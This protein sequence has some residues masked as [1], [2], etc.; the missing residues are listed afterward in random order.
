MAQGF[1]FADALQ[2]PPPE[3]REQPTG[4]FSFADAVKPAGFSFAEASQP[5]STSIWTDAADF[6]KRMMGS[7]ISGIFGAPLGAE[8]ALKGT[9][10]SAMEGTP[11]AIMPAS[12]Y[13]PGLDT[14]EALFGPE[15]KEERGRRKLQAQESR[16][17]TVKCR[18]FASDGVCQTP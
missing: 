9:A 11:E 15:S 3:K 14:E 12:V 2:P 13:Q 8:Q 1:S 17:V 10:R 4:G 6:S 7:A 5:E 18:L 16:L